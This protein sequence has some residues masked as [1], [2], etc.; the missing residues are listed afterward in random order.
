WQIISASD[1]RVPGLT[2]AERSTFG[3]QFSSGSAVNRAVHPA[4][5]EKR[6]VSRIHNGIDLEL[7]DVAADDVDLSESAQSVS[8]RSSERGRRQSPVYFTGPE[9]CFA[10]KFRND[11]FED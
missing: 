10:V 3:E 2:T 7:R 1:F 11:L 8:D 9:R 6:R 5:A 4:A